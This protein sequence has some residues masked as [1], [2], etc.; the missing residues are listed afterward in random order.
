INANLSSE[1]DAFFNAVN[2][3]LKS[4]VNYNTPVIE[5]NGKKIKLKE[6]GATMIIENGKSHIVTDEVPE[7]EI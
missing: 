6:K 2:N 4:G 7:L 1:G 5:L 3:T